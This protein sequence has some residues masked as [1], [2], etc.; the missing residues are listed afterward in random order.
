MNFS[1]S[2]YDVLLKNR[3]GRGVY[4]KSNTLKFWLKQEWYRKSGFWH[5]KAVTSMTRGKIGPRLLLMSL[6]LNLNLIVDGPGSDLKLFT[7]GALTT[8][9]GRLFQC[10]TTR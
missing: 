6:S 1:E 10:G 7:E 2:I 5:T 8:C 4:S 9:C 3:F